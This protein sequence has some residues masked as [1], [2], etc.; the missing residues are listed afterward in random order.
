MHIPILTD[1]P[2]VTIFEAFYRHFI[3]RSRG[4]AVQDYSIYFPVRHL[5]P[6]EPAARGGVRASR[7]GP[8]G[9]RRGARQVIAKRPTTSAA[10]PLLA[11]GP[12]SAVLAAG[13]R[14][15]RGEGKQR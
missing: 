4:G 15:P 1:N 12:A 8:A 7:S 14:A 10:D 13:R 2:V 3:A 11:D 5:A 9:L 6:P